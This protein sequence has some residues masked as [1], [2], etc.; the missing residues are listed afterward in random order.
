MKNHKIF[1]PIIFIVLLFEGC[2]VDPEYYTEVN[3]STFYDSPESVYQRLAS[4][5]IHWSNNEVGYTYSG[6]GY[7]QE[8]TSDEMCLPVRGGHWYDGGVWLLAQQHEFSPT[9][10]G[11]STAWNTVGIG[12]ARALNIKEDLDTYV[13]F[14]TMF[15]TN[16]NARSEILLQMDVLLATFYLKGLDFFGGIPIYKSNN[17]GMLPRSTDVEVFEH[18]DSLL[19]NAIPKLPK[20]TD[21]NALQDGYVNQGVAAALLARL[22]F[23]AESYIGEEMYDECAI[24]CS[25]I[26]DGKYGKYELA[27]DFRKIFGWGNETCSEIIWSVPSDFTKRKVSMNFEHT[28]HYNS[29]YTLNN[30]EMTAYNGFCLM[31]SLDGDGKSYII[32]KPNSSPKAFKLGS[33]FGKFEDSDVRKQQYKYKGGG[34][35]TG[36]FLCGLQDGC[37]GDNEYKGEIISFVDQMAYM[38]YHG[39]ENFKEGIQYAEENSG[40]RLVKFS[41]IPD[42]ADK[43]M[44]FDPDLP[45]IRLTEI[46]YMLAECKFRN[47]D[48]AG[49]A[50]LINNIRKRYFENGN[51]PN[52]VT[53]G[54]LDK[55]RLLDEWLIEFL[56]EKRRRTDL[57]R[58]NE[59]TE[60]RWFDH[61]PDGESKAYLNRFPIPQEALGA[62]PLLEQN[63]G[64]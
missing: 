11:M 59:F 60:G 43:S 10:Y 5:Y 26:I 12:I 57:I 50:S 18:I 28:L 40:I 17:D 29:K 3:P 55:Y 52:P 33:P 38:K 27:D 34:T 58:W 45:V 64:Y 36:M 48:L 31:P 61:E 41:P 20:K 2:N 16:P 62:N 7:L 22:Y 53:T 6:F 49:A 54:N 4:A 21:L 44:R 1:L 32:G 23:N 19:Q 15:P 37:L 51:D 13:D 9:A 24:I 46:H 25:D 56:G 30:P 14:E 47:N 35:Y 63:P 42:E 39:T 8:F